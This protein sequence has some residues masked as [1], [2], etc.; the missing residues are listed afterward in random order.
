MR[1]RAALSC[2][3]PLRLSRW[4]ARLDDQTGSGVLLC[5]GRRRR[6]VEAFDAGGQERREQAWRDEQAAQLAEQRATLAAGEPVRCEC[7]L[8]MIESA[9]EAAEKDGTLVEIGDCEQQ[10]G[11][12]DDSPDDPEEAFE[13]A[14]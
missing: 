14:A 10:W 4:R 2:R 13:E 3:L 8:R 5:G 6:A 9:E 1:C 7:C 11:S 12:A